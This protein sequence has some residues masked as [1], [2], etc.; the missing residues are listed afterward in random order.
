MDVS[1]KKNLNINL[2]HSLTDFARLNH[3]D[4]LLMSNLK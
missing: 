3:A 1:F 4:E 2:S